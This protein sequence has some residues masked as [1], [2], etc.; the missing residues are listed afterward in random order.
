LPLGFFA[1]VLSQA[2][3]AITCCGNGKTFSTSRD[4]AE[5]YQCS[6]DL[7]QSSPLYEQRSL[8]VSKETGGCND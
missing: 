4:L 3:Y 8:L 7:F 5:V 1:V 6:K 2:A